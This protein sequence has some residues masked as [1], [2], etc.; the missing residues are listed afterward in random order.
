MLPTDPDAAAE[1]RPDAAPAPMP[2]GLVDQPILAPVPAAPVGRRRGWAFGVSMV[3]V[4]VMGGGALFM[5]GYSVGVDQ[6]RTPGSS[7]SERDAWQPFWDVYRAITT[8]YPL[9]PIER[10]TLIEGAIRGMVESVGDPY[11]SY[12]SPADFTGTLNDISGTF[13]GIGAEIGSVDASGNT[14]DCNRYGPDCFLVVIAPLPGSPAEAAGLRPGDVILEVDG[15]RLD[16]LTPDEARDRV[17]GK[18]GTEVKLHIQRFAAPVRATP[19]PT[20]APAPSSPGSPAPS[21][22]PKPRQIL[23]DFEVT[24]VRAK[25]QRREV[26]SRDLAGGEVG[27]V[28]LGGFSSAGAKELET[29]IQAHLDKGVRKLVLDLRGNPGGFLLDSLDVASEFIAEG[30]IYWQE[31]ASGVQTVSDARPGGIATDPSI[32]VVV[33]IDRGTASAGEIVAGALQDRGRA[34]LIG[35]T[36]FGKGTVQEWI[37]LGELGG[38]KLTTNKWLTPNRTWI[39]KVGITPDI[40]VTVPPDLPQGSDPVLDEALEVLGAAAVAPR[41]YLRAA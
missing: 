20:A 39:H 4:A 38:V 11:S 15:S 6:G 29:A 5:S 25:I 35:E 13:E 27:Y 2:T 37:E 40:P 36:T 31:D 3:L 1:G 14:S 17:R 23:D 32:Q 19:G 28:S 22:T 26:T 41:Y 30:P 33:L 18:A 10:S 21:A 7:I 12:L 16:G 24:I 34:K 9:E 8:R